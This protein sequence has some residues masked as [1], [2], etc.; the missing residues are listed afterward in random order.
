M[1]Y[2]IIKVYDAQILDHNENNITLIHVCNQCETT[3]EVV[4]RMVNEGILNPIGKNKVQWRFSFTAVE[5][6]LKVKRLQRDLNVNLA[7]AA[8]AIELM[9]RVKVLE[10]LLATR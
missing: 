8:L 7:G 2:D 4:I 5:T 9:D 1:K 6:I 10:R 3:P